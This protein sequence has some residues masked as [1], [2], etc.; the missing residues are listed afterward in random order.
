M[1]NLRQ[2]RSAA[3]CSV[4]PFAHLH[5]LHTPKQKQKRL[6]SPFGGSRLRH[7]LCPSLKRPD[8]KRASQPLHFGLFLSQVSMVTISPRLS[9]VPPFMPNCSELRVCEVRHSP[10]SIGQVSREVA[11][12]R[13]A[14]PCYTMEQRTLLA[15][16]VSTPKG[17]R[18][19]Q[20]RCL[21]PRTAGRLLRRTSE[22]N[23]S[24]RFGE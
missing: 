10:G 7:W 5:S 19:A 23:P 21:P 17:W 9:R 4:S 14:T 24:R 22:N 2:P 13:V 20:V 12:L 16:G 8:G 6:T 3:R 18:H 15:R 11:P 1:P